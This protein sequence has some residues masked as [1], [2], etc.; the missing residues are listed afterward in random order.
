MNTVVSMKTPHREQHAARIRQLM[1]D[2]TNNSIALGEELRAARDTF[3][4]GAKNA[5]LGWSQWLRAEFGITERRARSLIQVATQFGC[6]AA[7]VNVGGRVLEFL[8][9]KTVPPKGREEVIARL[10]KGERI[11]REQA[12]EIVAKHRPTPTKAIEIAQE[13]GKIVEAS[14]GYL[15]TGAS[16]Q[17][18][19]ES[20]ERRTLV[21]AV[22]RAVETLA[23]VQ[24][25]ADQFIEY[26]LPHQLWNEQ[27]EGQ[28]EL[29]AAWL[30]SLNKVWKRRK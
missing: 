14:D 22:H 16:K 4:I 27:E 3:P 8:A 30:N 2:W 26:A 28:I 19:K 15:Y 12:K 6:A 13:T 20:T 5:R 10:K 24:L 25:T 17:Q 9:T 7:E 21:Y 23:T 1:Q 11:G 18:M 29:A